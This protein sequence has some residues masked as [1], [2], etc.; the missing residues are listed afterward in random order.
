MITINGN[1]Y[2]K[3]LQTMM[4]GNWDHGEVPQAVLIVIP[5]TRD[6]IFFQFMFLHRISSWIQVMTTRDSSET[7]FRDLK[8]AVRQKFGENLNIFLC[9]SRTK[10]IEDF[11]RA[12]KI[13]PKKYDCEHKKHMKQEL[14]KKEQPGCNMCALETNETKVKNTNSQIQTRCMVCEKR[15]KISSIRVCKCQNAFCTEH[16]IAHDCSF[17]YKQQQRKFIR[18]QLFS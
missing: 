10:K 1:E 12:I 13:E 18:E 6:N 15:L 7:L 9:T 4:F 16:I 8:Y 5:T 3:R 17:D 2:E 14:S 11:T